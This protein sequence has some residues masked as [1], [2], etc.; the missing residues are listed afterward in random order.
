MCKEVTVNFKDVSKSYVLN[1][2]MSSGFKNMLLHL[3]RRPGTLRHK[4][5]VH[6]LHRVSFE[7]FKGESLGIIGRNGSGKSTILGLIAGV[8][9]PSSGI[10]QVTGRISPL[11]ELGAGFH[12]E[13]SGTDNIML[14]GVLLGMT[15]QQVKGKIERIVEFSGLGDFVREPLRTYSTGMVARLGFSVVVHVDPQI[16]LID[17]VLAVGDEEFQKKCLAEME[18]FRSRGVTIVFVSHDLAS[19][20]RLCDSVALIDKGEL[21]D[22]AEPAKV[23]A[24]YRARLH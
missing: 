18:A 8:L 3:S 7:V 23:I 9:K 13:L 20:E 14:N 11:L 17:E 21:I 19:V 4:N 6:A 22:L 12:P 24:K 16:L 10:V 2:Y 5:V 1:T 15:K